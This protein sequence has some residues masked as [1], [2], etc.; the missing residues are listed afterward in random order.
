M[1]AEKHKVDPYRKLSQDLLEHVHAEA[2]GKGF[3]LVV[4]ARKLLESPRKQ[5]V[6]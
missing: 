4:I 5:Q 6:P 2:A 1:L 3:K